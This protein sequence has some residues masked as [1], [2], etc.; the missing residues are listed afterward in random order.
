ML[1][2]KNDDN[3]LLKI[4]VFVATFVGVLFF[5]VGLVW[6]LDNVAEDESKSVNSVFASPLYQ[7]EQS[8]NSENIEGSQEII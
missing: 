2:K 1:R 4:I 8:E 7:A 3:K 6:H 5:I